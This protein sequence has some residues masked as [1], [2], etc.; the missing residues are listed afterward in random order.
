MSKIISNIVCLQNFECTT[1][2]IL[3][4]I[5]EFYRFPSGENIGRFNTL[6]AGAELLFMVMQGRDYRNSEAVN[7]GT[8]G[9]PL[10]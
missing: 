2:L 10:R 7:R 5:S 9:R 6:R 3:G 1:L 4:D 8:T